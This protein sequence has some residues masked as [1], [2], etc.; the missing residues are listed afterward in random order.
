MMIVYN[1]NLTLYSNFIDGQ[2]KALHTAYNTQSSQ[3]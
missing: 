2:S 3:S 1:K